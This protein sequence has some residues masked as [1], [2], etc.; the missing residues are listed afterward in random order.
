MVKYATIAIT[1]K[2][3][4]KCMMCN[5]WKTGITQGEISA[6]AFGQLF[7]RPYFRE[8]I[9]IGISG[10][11]P[12]MRA[13]VVSVVQNIV[14]NLPKLQHIWMNTNGT[15]PKRIE[16]F[17]RG[18]YGMVPNEHLCISI[19]GTRGNNRKVRG[20]DSY[21]SAIQ[22]L[23]IC[24]K[25]FPNLQVHLSTTITPHNSDISNLKHIMEIADIHGCSHTFRF[26]NTNDDFY[27]NGGVDLKI[28]EKD[29]DKIIEFA[30]KHQDEFITAQKEFIRTGK[31]PV[32]SGCRAGHDFV[33]V[34]PDGTM[35]PCINSPRILD[36]PALIPDLGKQEQCPC[37]TECCFYPMLTYKKS[38]YR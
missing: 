30:C 19:E 21:N 24:R 35:T 3:N 5:I 22:T 15:S 4:S 32:M 11:E 17:Y 34:R 12:V 37:C 25:Q 38:N 33:F 9:D 28:P 7:A 27:Q 6:D 31:I 36:V 29:M 20:I 13:D 14:K 1:N 8:I 23:Q 18:T 2:C 16:D 26:A 10:G